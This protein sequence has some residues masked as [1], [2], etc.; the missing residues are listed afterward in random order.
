MR[1]F[2]S[3]SLTYSVMRDT[4]YWLS[5]RQAVPIANRLQKVLDLTEHQRALVVSYLRGSYVQE[6]LEMRF[7]PNDLIAITGFMT[8]YDAEYPC[9]SGRSASVSYVVANLNSGSICV[10]SHGGWKHE[11]AS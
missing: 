11:G 7:A 4:G 2:T 3:L 8:W 1:I 5:K 10:F 9:P 6:E